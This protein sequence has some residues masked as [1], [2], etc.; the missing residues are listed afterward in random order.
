MAHIY[1]LLWLPP[2]SAYK[3]ARN[4]YAEM[5]V[6]VLNIVLSIKR[7]TYLIFPTTFA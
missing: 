6:D 3:K 5:R 4:C 2:K 1:K 7:V